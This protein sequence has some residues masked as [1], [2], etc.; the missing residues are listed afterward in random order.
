MSSYGM[1]TNGSGKDHGK[2]GAQSGSSQYR[3]RD[4]NSGGVSKRAEVLT[5]E[6]KFHEWLEAACVRLAVG[7]KAEWVCLFGEDRVIPTPMPINERIKRQ[8]KAWEETHTGPGA[9]TPISVKEEDQ[10]NLNDLYEGNVDLNAIKDKETLK[11]LL[12]TAIANKKNSAVNPIKEEEMREMAAKNAVKDWNREYERLHKSDKQA[13]FVD[14]WNHISDSIRERM[15][16]QMGWTLCMEE[17]DVVTLLN[18]AEACQDRT[19][20]QMCEDDEMSRIMASE[21]V[22]NLKMKGSQSISDFKKDVAAAFATRDRFT[23]EDEPKS[24]GTEKVLIFVRGLSAAHSRF[25]HYFEDLARDERPTDLE[26]LVALIS[27]YEASHDRVFK[28]DYRGSR[29]NNQGQLAIHHAASNKK[30]LGRKEAG[31]NNKMSRGPKPDDKCGGCGGIGHWKRDCPTANAMKKSAA[32]GATEDA[33][34]TKVGQI[35]VIED[36]AV[37]KCDGVLLDDVILVEYTHNK[38]SPLGKCPPQWIHLDNGAEGSVF[39]NPELLTN[40][41]NGDPV[42]ITTVAGSKRI[43]TWGWYGPV[44]V[45]LDEGGEINLLAQHDLERVCSDVHFSFEENK[46]TCVLKDS[47]EVWEFKKY[48]RG[49]FGQS[50]RLYAYVPSAARIFATSVHERE[51]KFTRD[52][53][54]RAKGVR[55]LKMR[56]GGA[57]DHDLVQFLTSGVAVGC[58]YTAADVRRA[59]LI[60]GPD[61]AGLKGKTTASGPKK[62]IVLELEDIGE[63]RKQSLFVDIFEVEKQPFV[64]AVMKPLHYRFCAI[65]D[66]KQA[67]DIKKALVAILDM[68]TSKGFMVKRVEVDPE[69]GLAAIQHKLGLDMQITGAGSHVAIAERGGRVVKE[70]CRLII[71]SLPYSLPARLTRYLVMFAVT[72]LNLMPRPGDGSNLCPRERFT[73]KKLMYKREL[74]VGFGD[75]AEVWS[76]PKQSNSMEPRTI[77]SI[78]LCPVGNDEGSWYFYDLMECTVIQ[79]SQWKVLPIPDIVVRILNELARTDLSALGKG[80]PVPMTR[81]TPMVGEIPADRMIVNPSLDVPRYGPDGERLGV[82]IKPRRNRKKV[83]T[84]AAV[85]EPVEEAV[86]ADGPHVIDADDVAGG[87]VIDP[88]TLTAD[89]DADGLIGGDQL[90]GDDN[91]A[92]DGGNDELNFPELFEEER[93]EDAAVDEDNQADDDGVVE[94]ELGYVVNDDGV[95]KSSRLALKKRDFRAEIG[96]HKMSVKEAVQKFGE[97]GKEAFRKEFRNMVALEVFAPIRYEDITEDQ[98][99]RIIHSSAFLTEKYDE[100]GQMIGVKARWV[101][102][103]NEM[104]RNLYESGSS[105]TISIE[106]LFIVFALCAGADMS[107]C[108]MD[109]GS[110]FLHSQMKEFVAVYISA[111][112]AQFVVEVMPSAAAYLDKKGRLLVKLNKALYGCIQSSRLWYNHM[113]EVLKEYG[114]RP[115]AYEPCIYTKGEVG[116]QVIVGMHVDDLFVCANTKELR[117]ECV[118]FLKPRFIEVKMK[119]GSVNSYLGMRVR[120]TEDSIEVDMSVYIDECLE[121]SKVPGTAATPATSDLFEIGDEEPLVGKSEQEDFHTGVAKLLYLAKRCR[122]D[123]LPAVSFLTSRVGKVTAKDVSKLQRVFKFLRYTK[124]RAMRFIKNVS[125]PDLVAYVDAGYGIHQEGESRSGLVVTLNGTPV[126]WKTAKQSI[127]TKSSTEAE[128]VAL[129]DGCSDILWARQMLMDQGYKLDATTVGEDNMSVLSM[130]ERR[131]FST[132]RTKHINIRY[133]FIVDRI[134]SGELKMVHVPTDLMVADFMTKPLTGKQFNVL[135]DRL[136]GPSKPSARDQVA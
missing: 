96:L 124:D 55:E 28:A 79:R 68:I 6:S 91:G 8:M 22:M 33:S 56:L 114:F 116:S 44:R 16:L 1:K 89:E 77:S 34:M 66:G 86:G 110:A 100:N 31:T 53:V 70:R 108:T 15:M 40:I 18:L 125:E 32:G 35:S 41:E 106:A 87:A 14:L 121:W 109:I 75:Y 119:L 90:Q 134:K 36:N 4:W 76:K 30:A 101:G 49:E 84:V 51:S 102:S 132:A 82:T 13:I 23:R 3:R 46:F 127:V 2:I 5:T 98:K 9:S 45:L 7:D 94:E 131:K 107:W 118:E 85:G 50:S 20:I 103:G 26:E 93:D 63:Q 115:N 81:G 29:G 80:A 11:T 21:A 128:L 65:L 43:S 12:K 54:Q 99:Q 97:V 120:D 47:G 74:E 104:N 105:P 25:K 122:P 88:M 39:S 27:R 24:T 69:R 95:R 64:L 67:E 72:R 129:S 130:L 92:I 135:Q 71:A 37:N 59:T 38:K 58:P 113:D 61:I 60:Y 62:P 123:I 57:S 73:G 133:F 126:L 117:D 78:A 52:E 48:P 83:A 10:D 136:F 111:A 112:L 19:A 17:R 42:T